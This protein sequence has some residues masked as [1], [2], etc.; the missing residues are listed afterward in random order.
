MAKIAVIKTGGKQYKVKEGQVLSIEKLD[1]AAGDKVKFE[2]LLLADSET[3]EATIGKPFLGEQVEGKIVSQ[4]KDDKVMVIKFKNKI[5]YK[6]TAG[7]RQQI[8]KVEIT[9]IA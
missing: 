6:R 1:A 9:K 3:G 5:R 4:T 8:T 7:H 2:T